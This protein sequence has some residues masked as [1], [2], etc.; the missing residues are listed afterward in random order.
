MLA[1]LRVRAYRPLAIASLMLVVLM[2]V[3]VRSA[4]Y[5][6][7]HHWYPVMPALATGVALGVAS[8]WRARAA[9]GL[10]RAA[11]AGVILA[12]PVWQYTV[13]PQRQF[14]GAAPAERW[15]GEYR[16]AEPVAEFIR[17]GVKPSETV[18][19]AGGYPSVLWLAERFAPTRWIDTPP[20]RWWPDYA[21]PERRSDLLSAPPK[22]LVSLSG[23]ALDPALRALLG[24]YRYQLAYDRARSRV[25]LRAG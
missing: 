2:L 22:A 5:E 10:S 15:G 23:A 3:R 14:L 16:Q 20:I 8:L 4:G 18:M 21:V 25:W 24:R 17:R 11:L 1:A 12:F 13:Q 7:A 6:Y 9:N 19:V